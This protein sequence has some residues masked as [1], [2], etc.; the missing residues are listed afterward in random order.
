MAHLIEPMHNE[1]FVAVL[2]EHYPTRQEARM[3]LNELPLVA[4]SWALND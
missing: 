4:E 2:G 1:N 3:E